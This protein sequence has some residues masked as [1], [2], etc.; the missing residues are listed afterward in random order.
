[1]SVCL[2]LRMNQFMSENISDDHFLDQSRLKY[3]DYAN[4]PCE[5]CSLQNQ[6]YNP[7]IC[8]LFLQ[9]SLPANSFSIS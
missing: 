5:F 6:I 7:T 9:K 3:I 4:L 1:M 8:L 2:S